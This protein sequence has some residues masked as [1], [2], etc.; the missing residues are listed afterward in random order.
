MNALMNAFMAGASGAQGTM[1]NAAVAF[2]VPRPSIREKLGFVN[3]CW[4]QPIGKQLPAGGPADALTS[5]D[6]HT[7][8]V[9]G[10]GGGFQQK[11]ES[12]LEQ[13]NVQH[14]A[15]DATETSGCK[16]TKHNDAKHPSSVTLCLST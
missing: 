10:D 14:D 9:S 11:G 6:A 7:L 12:A 2:S 8:E 13:L 1:Q 4:L 3:A 16:R 15:C 5:T